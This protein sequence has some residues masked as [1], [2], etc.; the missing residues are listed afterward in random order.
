MHDPVHAFAPFAAALDPILRAA[1]PDREIVCWRDEAE[2]TAGI[3][4]VSYL[5][6]LG[7]PRGHWAG[8]QRLKL[9]H[10]LGAG[11]DDVLPASDLPERVVVANNRGMSAESMAEFGL[12]L[13]LALVKKLPLF[14]EAQRAHEWRRAL[15]GLAAGSTL[16]I[17]G[18]G[19]IGQALAEK[20]GGL[21]MRVLASQRTPKSH[22]MVEEVFDAAS[23]LE[24]LARSDVV[25][26]LL[27]LTEKTRGSFGA[28]EFAAMKSDGMLVNLARGGIVDETALLSALG[29]RQ[30]AGAIFDVFASE[31]LPADSP[32]WDAPNLWI[33]PHT[34][35]GFPDLLERAIDGFAENVRRME[36][37]EP[38]LNRVDREQG[39]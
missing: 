8:A 36:R 28:R 34:A 6:A 16:G 18:M 3:S 37:G 11:V 19:A 15:P 38:V 27:P 29:D 4:D 10:C 17:V 12:A 2:F 23:T 14:V 33:T 24:L 5:F 39:Y 13:V 22:P 1:L 7:P 25:V 9:I 30:I 31:P 21:G 32:L 35:G 26:L 20:A